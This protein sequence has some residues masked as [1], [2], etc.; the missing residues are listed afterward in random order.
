MKQEATVTARKGIS[1]LKVKLPE[2]APN[3]AYHISMSI[4][5]PKQAE[6][7]QPVIMEVNQK[8]EDEFII[9]FGSK[10]VEKLTISYIVES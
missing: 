4:I 9:T 3:K 5:E 1:K 10:T 8:D 6:L 7:Q 2:A